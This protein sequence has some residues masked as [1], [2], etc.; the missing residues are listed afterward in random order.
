ML[1]HRSFS[2]LFIRLTYTFVIIWL[3]RKLFYVGK[4]LAN[5]K[6]K[7]KYSS[8]LRQKLW[9]KYGSIHS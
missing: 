4:M 7:L 1:K 3:E 9:K 2:V 6:K 8:V 5:G